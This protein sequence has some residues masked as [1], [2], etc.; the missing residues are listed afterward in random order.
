[1]PTVNLNNQL[2]LS[3]A[4]TNRAQS[5]QWYRTHLGFEEVLSIDEAGW[6]E[7]KTTVPGVTLGLG[8][9]DKVSP[10]NCVPV[11]GVSDINEA[12]SALEDRSVKFDGDTITIEGMVSLAT[13]YDPD[14]NAIMLAED[15]SSTE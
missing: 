15:L 6:T 5:A 3:L 14:G 13:F 8:D 4:V 9:T 10:G 11:F 1:M 12:R 7:L 2:T